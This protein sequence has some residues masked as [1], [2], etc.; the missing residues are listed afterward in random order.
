MPAATGRPTNRF[1][2]CSNH[3]WDSNN[4]NNK[5]AK[6]QAACISVLYS[7]AHNVISI[8]PPWYRRDDMRTY[9]RCLISM[10]VF[11]ISVLWLRQCRCRVC[12]RLCLC[13]LLW[14]WAKCFL[15]F[16]VG[17]FRFSLSASVVH[18]LFF[19]T[20]LELDDVAVFLYALIAFYCLF[21]VFVVCFG[22]ACI[23]HAFIYSAVFFALFFFV[24]SILSYRAF[25]L[26][27][28]HCRR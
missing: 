22:F 2:C 21:T 28:F 15:P 20:L 25:Y 16:V 26:S 5:K 12:A 1:D 4:N 11:C 24:V 23:W 10:F 13:V 3:H 27:L 9:I 17:C 6:K 14:D 18:L 7:Y 19:V 8:L